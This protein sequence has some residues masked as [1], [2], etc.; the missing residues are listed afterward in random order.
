MTIIIIIIPKDVQPHIDKYKTKSK[1]NFFLQ[2]VSTHFLLFCNPLKFTHIQFPIFIY[3]Y[4]RTH[5]F[6][7]VCINFDLTIG[8]CRGEAKEA[9]PCASLCSKS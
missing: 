6:M 9:R 4:I 1:S 3:V 2:F 5:V 7:Y 8:Y